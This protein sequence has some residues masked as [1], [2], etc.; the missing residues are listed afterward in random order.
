VALPSSTLTPHAI[1]IPQNIKQSIAK[2]GKSRKTAL[3]TA[4]GHILPAK[5]VYFSDLGVLGGANFQRSVADQT[6]RI[7]KENSYPPRHRGHKKSRSR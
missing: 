6:D 7:E 2:H 1:V 4:P 5:P 3:F